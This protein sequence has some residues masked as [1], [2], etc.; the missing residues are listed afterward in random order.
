MAENKNRCG[1]RSHLAGGDQSFGGDLSHRVAADRVDGRR[2]RRRRL[3]P[4][5][6]ARPALRRERR[7]RRAANKVLGPVGKK[8]PIF[9]LTK[10]STNLVDSSGTYSTK[11][12]ID[13][14]RRAL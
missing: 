7:R 5:R 10:N 2:R 6:L 8:K 9:S 4:R 1:S 13:C 3:R 11:T 12:S 14:L